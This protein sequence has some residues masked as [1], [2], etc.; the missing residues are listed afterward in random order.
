V[1]ITQG[2]GRLCDC[3]PTLSEE[4][5]RV[6]LGLAELG[7]RESGGR[8]YCV[9]RGGTVTGWDTASIGILGSGRFSRLI[10]GEVGGEE[11]SDVGD[12]CRESGDSM[13]EGWP[14]SCRSRE[15]ARDARDGA[16]DGGRETVDPRLGTGAP[17]DV[18]KAILRSFALAPALDVK[19]LSLISRNAPCPFTPV[20]PCTWSPSFVPDLL[21][22]RASFL[23]LAGCTSI[24]R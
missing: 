9:G 24:L 3:V 11:E 21:I 2:A 14:Y 20:S 23:G 5:L 4:R 19:L 18:S 7:L 6:G 13:V 8:V 16:R 12:T 15:E 1:M 10:M 22:L 17:K